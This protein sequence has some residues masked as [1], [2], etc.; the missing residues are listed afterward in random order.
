MYLHGQELL[1]K[2]KSIE[3][4]VTSSNNSTGGSAGSAV[5]GIKLKPKCVPGGRSAVVIIEILDG[6]QACVEN[7]EDCRSLGRF[8]LRATGGTVAVGVVSM[9]G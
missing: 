9:E 1:V 3:S 2:I 4:M 7:F 8:A 5:K 6:K